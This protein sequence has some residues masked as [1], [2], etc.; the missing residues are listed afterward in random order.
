[1]TLKH[2]KDL[3]LQKIKTETDNPQDWKLKQWIGNESINPV[4]L[5]KDMQREG[6]I[7]IE[8]EDDRG[9]I[10]RRLKVLK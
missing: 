9:K 2:Y 1:M 7:Q 4:R 3:I 5:I 10:R 8:F 6:T